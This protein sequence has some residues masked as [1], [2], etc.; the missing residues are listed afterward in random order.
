VA[1]ETVATV[2]ECYIAQNGCSIQVWLDKASLDRVFEAVHRTGEVVVIWQ[3]EEWETTSL[4]VVP[5]RGGITFHAHSWRADHLFYFNEQGQ[6]IAS[7]DGAKH[8]IRADKYNQAKVTIADWHDRAELVSAPGV[9]AAVLE[10]ADRVQPRTP[11]T[12]PPGP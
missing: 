6:R 9:R 8:Q 7:A 4:T 3:I 5:P 1:E 2:Y 11:P 10:L 12:P